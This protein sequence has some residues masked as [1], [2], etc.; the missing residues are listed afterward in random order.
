V[1]APWDEDETVESFLPALRQ[2]GGE[3]TICAAYASAFPYRS[4]F[5]GTFFVIC[6]DGEHLVSNLPIR[7]HNR[8]GEPTRYSR[9]VFTG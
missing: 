5:G 4:S 3:D 6:G 2:N 1:D 7:P 8:V 9:E